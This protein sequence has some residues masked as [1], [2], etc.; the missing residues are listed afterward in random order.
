MEEWITY[1]SE[2]STIIEKIYSNN[3]RNILFKRVMFEDK[4]TIN[5]Y[6]STL[7]ER[8][9]LKGVDLY[10]LMVE[11]LSRYFLYEYNN[12]LI[13]FFE[14]INSFNSFIEI[15]DKFIHSEKR[16]SLGSSHKDH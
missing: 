10:Q 7:S 3:H 2:S 5:D 1:N 9:M 8:N 15:V 13:P 16:I 6:F 11:L 4:E 12:D 14:K